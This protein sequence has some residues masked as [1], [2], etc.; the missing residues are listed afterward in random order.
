MRF[1]DLALFALIFNLALGLLSTLDIT[2]APIES[3]DGFGQDEINEGQSQIES[4][5][6]QSDQ[7]I[8]SDLEWLVENVRLVL[9]GIKTFITVLA[10]ATIFLPFMLKTLMCGAG[11]CVGNAPLEYTAFMIGLLVQFIYVIG[12]IQFAMGKSLKEAV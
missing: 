10:N 6:S 4:V 5:L 11:G 1:Y 3:M 12:I 9:Q 2:G 8:F 7:S